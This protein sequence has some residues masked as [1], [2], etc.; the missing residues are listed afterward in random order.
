M[1]TYTILKVTKNPPFEEDPPTRSARILVANGNNYIL[2][3]NGL[4][5]TGGLRPILDAQ[6]EQLWADA[7]TVNQL[8]TEA[9][10]ALANGINWYNANPGTK[11]LFT[12]TTADLETQINTL[13]DAVMPT[14]SAANRTK[15]KKFWTA[16]AVAVRVSVQGDLGEIA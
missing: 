12:T 4:P 11:I 10:I 2:T 7:V 9:E 3:V 16:L 8:A 5:E 1:T 13:V 14:A 15:V 6:L